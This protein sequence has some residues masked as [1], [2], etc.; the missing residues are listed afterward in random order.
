MGVVPLEV[1]Q[2]RSTKRVQFPGIEE[3]KNPTNSL[4]LQGIL[5]KTETNIRLSLFLLFFPFFSARQQTVNI[6]LDSGR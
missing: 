2:I 5:Q 3:E 6:H 4:H 1:N